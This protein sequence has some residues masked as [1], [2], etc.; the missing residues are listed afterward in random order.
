MPVE[1]VYDPVTDP[2]ELMAH[3]DV[4]CRMP[5]PAPGASNV[6]NVDCA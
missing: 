4:P 6:V 2:V 3:A 5:W 1:S